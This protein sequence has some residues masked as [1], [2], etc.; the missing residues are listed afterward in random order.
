MEACKDEN[1][2]FLPPQQD[3]SVYP[4]KQPGILSRLW[5]YVRLLVEVVMALCI[6]VLTS[7]LAR[8]ETTSGEFADSL[9][10]SPVPK[11]KPIPTYRH[12]GKQLIASPV[13]RK[14]YT[15]NGDERYLNE[16]MFNSQAETM[17]TLHQWIPLSSGKADPDF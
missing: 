8:S 10:K 13:P 3:R 17:H 12:L 2:A 14:L 1:E 4:A 11:C 5:P 9:R 7:S 16:D 15:F 6:F